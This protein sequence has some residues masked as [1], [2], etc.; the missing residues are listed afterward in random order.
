MGW[1]TELKIG[2]NYWVWRKNLP[3]EVPLLYFGKHKL[4]YNED[5]EIDLKNNKQFVGYEATVGQVISNLN[6]LGLTLDFFI[7]TY[8]SYRENLNSWGISLLNG[9]KLYYKYND[10]KSAED[11]KKIR[12]I[13]IW[14]K[15]IEEGSAKKDIQS[16]ISILK[17]KIIIDSA[18]AEDEALIPSIINV[19]INQ[20]FNEPNFIEATNFGVFLE[21]AHNYLPEIAW[22]YEVRLVL[23]TLGKRTKVKLD[24]K[25]WVYEGG[26]IDIIKDSIEGLALKAKTYGK[27]FSAILEGNHTFNKEY[28]RTQLIEKW[29]YLIGLDDKDIYKGSKLEVFI[30]TLFHKKFGFE[31]LAK[32]LLVETQEL[33]L[34]I[35]NTSK[36]EFLKSL[37]SPF[38]LIECKNWTSPV[39]VSEARVFESKYRES[40]NKVNLGIFIALN[41]VTKPF[42]K[43]LNNLI[44]DGINLIVIDNKNIDEYLY[45][46]DLDISNWLEQLISKQFI[47][48]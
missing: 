31:V 21:Y 24:L 15:R 16:A 42:K 36:N 37:A 33:D 45:R 32:N 26:D 47:L 28:E 27:T 22:L 3:L 35:K 29:N 25:E 39:G 6:N 30:E 10:K 17:D 43:H 11:L 1:Y 19:R 34:V 40:G 41:G 13:N 20:D 7:S 12:K 48:K 44:R 9:R 46:E 2:D 4:C 18:L 5:L 23:E 14:I 38:I 8:A